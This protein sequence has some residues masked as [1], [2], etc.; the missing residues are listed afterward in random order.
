MTGG[1][2]ERILCAAMTRRL[3]I[4]DRGPLPWHLPAELR[5]FRALTWGHSL[6][7]GRSTFAAIGRPLPGRRNVVLSRSLPSRPGIIVCR[8]LEEAL[9]AAAAGMEKLFFIGG[10]QIYRQALPLVETMHISWVRG[11][12]S[13]EVRFPPFDPRP[14]QVVAATEHPG[15]RHVVYRRPGHS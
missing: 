6:I 10:A 13:G 8:S 14:W 12:F 3:V 7:M 1:D 9:A 2:V 15:F 11:D 5:L 4:G